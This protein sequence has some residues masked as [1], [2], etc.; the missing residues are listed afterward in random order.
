MS[1]KMGASGAGIIEFQGS[2]TTGSSGNN[3]AITGV[4]GL[5]LGSHRGTGLFHAGIIEVL[6]LYATSTLTGTNLTSLY[7]NEVTNTGAQ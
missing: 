6:G 2:Q 3:T 7:N 1:M 4:T 5:S